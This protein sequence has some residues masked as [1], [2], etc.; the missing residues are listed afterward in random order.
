MFAPMFPEM[1]KPQ[2]CGDRR[3][4]GGG[5]IVHLLRHVSEVVCDRVGLESS[6]PG[7][8]PFMNLGHIHGHAR[9]DVGLRSA[10]VEDKQLELRRVDERGKDHVVAHAVKLRVVLHLGGN[11]A[12]VDGIL[13]NAGVVGAGSPKAGRRGGCFRRARGQRPQLDLAIGVVDG[14]QVIGENIHPDQAVRIV[15]HGGTAAVDD[16]HR[17]VLELQVANFDGVGIGEIDRLAERSAGAHSVRR[18]SPACSA[19]LR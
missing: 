17:A 15:L 1:W 6:G 8:R 7:S 9:G 2:G 12:V 10:E 4:V 18:L 3:C 16:L 5:D 13:G 11:K 19:R 14:D